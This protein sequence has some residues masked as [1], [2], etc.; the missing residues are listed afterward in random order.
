MAHFNIFAHASALLVIDMQEAFCKAIPSI[1]TDQA[2]G[3]ACNTLIQ[4]AQILELPVLFSEQYPKGL[5]ATLPA[6]LD[7]A[8][9]NAQVLEK[10]HFSCCDDLT[11]REEI[12][13]LNRETIIICGIE[14]HVCVLGTC[15]D[16]IQ[17][18]FNVLVV[19]D[20]IDS[21]APFNRDSA[22]NAMRDLG[23]LVVPLESVILR[24]QRQAG[25]DSFKALSKL[26][27]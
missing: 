19:A 23:A 6:L 10:T 1:A 2:C 3:Q 20:A 27:R 25:G 22:I 18:G 15:A 5:G 4:A 12:A 14:A 26:I 8:P 24:L 11:L 13:A 9:D 21:R 7:A 16:L 17:R